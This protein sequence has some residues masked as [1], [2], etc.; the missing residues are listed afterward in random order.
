MSKAAELANLIGNINAGGGGVNRNLIINGNFLVAQRGTSFSSNNSGHYMMDRFRSE[1]NNDGA[2][3][4]S[5]STTAPDGFSKS[6]KVDITS[7]DT[8]LS[9]DQYQQIT[10]KVEA[11]DLQHLAYGTSAAKTITLSFYVR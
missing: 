3:T 4:I 11:Q 5:Q 7:T 10:Y 1:A 8:S 2:F 9:S 6:L